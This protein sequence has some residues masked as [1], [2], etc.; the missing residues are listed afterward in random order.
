MTNK[1]REVSQR[2]VDEKVGTENN[3]TAIATRS[4]IKECIKEFCEQMEETDYGYREA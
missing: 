4:L 2:V 3:T 1:Q